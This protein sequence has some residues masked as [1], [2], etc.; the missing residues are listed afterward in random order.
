MERRDD[1]QDDCALLATATLLGTGLTA[2]GST[3]SN[4]STSA[5]RATSVSSATENAFRAP[6]AAEYSVA[7]RDKDNDSAPIPGK[8]N[9]NAAEDDKNNNDILNFGHAANA[10][11]TKAITT[12][13][14]RYYTAAA[15]EDGADACSM[16]YVT[17]AESLPED[18][19]AGS[20]G[21]PYLKAGTT[22]AGVMGLLFKHYHDQLTAELPLLKVAHVRLV[23]RHGLAIL[24][25]G[26]MPERQLFVRQ[27]LGTWK[28]GAITDSALP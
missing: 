3:A 21:P 24:H 9:D 19:G 2:C 15:R 26:T 10:S 4:S 20:S 11:D 5:P 17:L 25:F 7:D 12:L 23:Q 13:V 18:Y 8:D 22:C 16:I 27:E 14:K 1:C 28:L 6:T